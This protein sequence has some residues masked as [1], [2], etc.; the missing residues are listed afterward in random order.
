MII[1]ERERER[2]R[3][4]RAY[5]KHFSEKNKR[6]YLNYSKDI[7]CIK[8]KFDITFGNGRCLFSKVIYYISYTFFKTKYF[9]MS[10][11]NY[12]LIVQQSVYSG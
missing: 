11:Q 4:K 2:E 3:E 10:A 9:M 12:G 5:N 8:N 1:V 6:D 7:C